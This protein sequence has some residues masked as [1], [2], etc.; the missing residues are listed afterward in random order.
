MN[1]D[2]DEKIL[3]DNEEK[4]STK[5]SKKKEASKDI[6]P[7]SFIKERE[8]ASGVDCHVKVDED[9]AYDDFSDAEGSVEDGE[10]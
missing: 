5:A 10:E 3:V 7:P 6:A 9:A 1:N 4:K 2:A 8:K